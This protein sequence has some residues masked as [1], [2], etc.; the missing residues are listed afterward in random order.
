MAKLS[1][2]EQRYIDLTYEALTLFTSGTG[3]RYITM[4][5]MKYESGT[6][7]KINGILS[8]RIEIGDLLK[9]EDKEND[10]DARD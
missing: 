4:D 8:R 2:L 6:L 9:E 7:D 5:I 1:K 10:R 3:G